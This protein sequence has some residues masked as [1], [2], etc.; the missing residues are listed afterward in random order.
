[1]C[2]P[3]QLKCLQ[4]I[5]VDTS[6]CINKC[7]GMMITSFSKEKYGGNIEGDIVKEFNAYKKYKKWFRT[8]DDT[9]IQG[10]LSKSLLTIYVLIVSEQA[11]NG[12]IN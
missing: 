4:T 12:K 3:E 8:K 10:E 2:T 7:N 5:A 6:I 1:M 11:I 9:V